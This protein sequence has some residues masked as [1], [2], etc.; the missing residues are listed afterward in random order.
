MSRV[1]RRAARFGLPLVV[2]AGLVSAIQA[3]PPYRVLQRHVL[4]GDDG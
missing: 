3:P 1:A 2:M 4:G